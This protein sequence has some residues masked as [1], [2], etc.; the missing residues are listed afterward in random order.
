M[1]KRGY[2]YGMRIERKLD[3]GVQGRGRGAIR[4]RSGRY[5]VDN[6]GS[7]GHGR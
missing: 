5:A 4:A 6:D 2:R 7:N 1:R 3:T